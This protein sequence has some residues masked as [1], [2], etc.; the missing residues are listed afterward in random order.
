METFELDPQLR[1]NLLKST[2]TH[3]RVRAF[4]S[5]TAVH[6]F[7]ESDPE[8]KCSDSFPADQWFQF[9]AQGKLTPSEPPA[10]S[11]ACRVNAIHY[12][13]TA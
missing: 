3:V 9:D 2:C 8:Q 11:T 10:R 6:G 13:E 5:A 1:D 12:A 7:A 4:G